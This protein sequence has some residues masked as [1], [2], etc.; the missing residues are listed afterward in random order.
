MRSQARVRAIALAALLAVSACSD[1][2]DGDT[3][4]PADDAASIDEET[5]DDEATVDGDEQ[6]SAV[7]RTVDLAQLDEDDLG[8]GWRLTNTTPA[9]EDDDESPLDECVDASYLGTFDDATIAESDERTF[10][11]SADTS[12]L[13]PQ[14]SSRAEALDDATLLSQRHDVLA[15]DDF[16]DCI[17]TTFQ[18]VATQQM[19]RGGGEATVGDV[20][21]RTD[22]VDVDGAESS[23]LS[24]PITLTTE[25]LTYELAISATYVD[26]GPLGVN[27]FVYGSA[28]TVTLEQE[29]E[30]ASLL[31][32]RLA[33]D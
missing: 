33:G 5:T 10:T 20:E 24:V 32:E 2:G 14:V 25:G 16:A 4:P 29:L 8:D 7:Q 28:G 23:R 15:S 17:A 12:P 6:R 1:D 21:V 18:D 26:I 3:T 9:G 30:W 27:L 11:L 19:V 13:P 22:V 31:A